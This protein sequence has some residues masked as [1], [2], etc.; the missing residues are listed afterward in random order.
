MEPSNGYM[1]LEDVE[2]GQLVETQELSRAIIL[3]K[4]PSSI[5][6]LVTDCPLVQDKQYYIGKHI[7]AGKTEVKIKE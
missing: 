7:W 4:S 5:T 6:V 2:I 3:N 1:F